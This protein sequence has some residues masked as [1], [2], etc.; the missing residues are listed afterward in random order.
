KVVC[1]VDKTLMISVSAKNT[2]KNNRGQAVLEYVLLTFIVVVVLG[3]IIAGL[4]YGTQR[5]AQ[6]YFGDY[7]QC[8]LETGELPTLGSDKVPNT[9]CDETHEP[10]T[11]KEGRPVV[12]NDVSGPSDQFPNGSSD[13][14]SSQNDAD[15]SGSSGSGASGGD[16]GPGAGSLGGSGSDSFTDGFGGR[17]KKVPLSAADKKGKDSGAAGASGGQGGFN[18]FE[19]AEE[20]GEDGEGRSS[21]IP[22]YGQGQLKD[23][24]KKS[25]DV[26]KATVEQNP[27]QVLRGKRVP[28]SIAK[29]EEKKSSADENITLPDFLKIIIIAAIILVIVIFFGGQVMNY[30]KSQ[31]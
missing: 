18:N 22:I 3:H 13:T 26:V 30:S 19:Q 24:E 16:G 14:D 17:N 12:F 15:P 29:E 6:N 1:V 31:D 7:F 23:E 27:E 20:F 9:E 5:F 8:L 11:F 25:D 21:Y 10:F 4:A 2:F 28:V